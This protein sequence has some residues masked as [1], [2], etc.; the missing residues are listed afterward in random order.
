MESKLA[1][2]KNAELRDALREIE[3]S[4]A[5]LPARFSSMKGVSASKLILFQ[6]EC[7]RSLTRDYSS[8]DEANAEADRLEAKAIELFSQVANKESK[9]KSKAIRQKNAKQ[10]KERKNKQLA[11]FKKAST[12][13]LLVPSPKQKIALKERFFRELLQK[14]NSV[15]KKV[16]AFKKK[17]MTIDEM[18]KLIKESEKKD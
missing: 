2:K 7:M 4:S 14:R 13:I 18:V 15:M 8:V 1:K 16:P 10:E 3:L 11:N 9:V 6:E 12:R 5:T 17:D